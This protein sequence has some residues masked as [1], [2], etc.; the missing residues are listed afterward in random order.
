M[1]P[2]VGSESSSSNCFRKLSNKSSSQSFE[3][4]S[5]FIQNEGH[6]SKRALEDDSI[7]K[8]K[9]IKTITHE[10][11][12]LEPTTVPTHDKCRLTTLFLSP[13]VKTNSTI[14]IGMFYSTDLR[15]DNFTCIHKI[16]KLFHYYFL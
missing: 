6:S 15:K 12:F 9:R 4:I 3:I 5:E 2:V 11:E 14:I 8:N 13:S 16:I 10:D 1:T 7:L